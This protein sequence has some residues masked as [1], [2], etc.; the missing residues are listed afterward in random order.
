MPPSGTDPTRKASSLPV[1]GSACCSLARGE[2]GCESRD[3]LHIYPRPGL[4]STKEGLPATG[5]ASCPLPSLS[6]LQDDSTGHGET[7]SGGPAKGSRGCQPCRRDVPPAPLLTF[8]GCLRL[9]PRQESLAP[10]LFISS[11]P[12]SEPP[13]GSLDPRALPFPDSPPPP[14]PAPLGLFLQPQGWNSSSPTFCP[15]A[16]RPPSLQLP[17]LPP[18]KTLSTSLSC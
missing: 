9:S 6:W 12:L 8:P 5:R 1:L 10:F 18:K 16:R 7:R 3:P 15:R 13:P 11:F 4:P 17:H 14:Q 2:R